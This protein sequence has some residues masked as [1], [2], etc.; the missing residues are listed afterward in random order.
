M[1]WNLDRII[2]YVRFFYFTSHRAEAIYA[3][4]AKM[5]RDPLL[6]AEKSNDPKTLTSHGYTAYSQ[7]D[8]D[9][10]LEEIFRR[11]GLTNRQF[12][13][14]GCGNGLENNSTYLLF[15]G[16]R[17]VWMDG[18]PKEI[19]NVEKHFRSYIQ[20]GQLKVKR[21]FITTDN[22]NDLIREVA[23][24]IQELDLLSIDING[25]DYWIWQALTGLRPRVVVI[26][27][28]A[29]FR[30]P[31]KIVQKYNPTHNWDGSNYFGAS[32]KAL[33][34]LGRQK[35]YILTGCNFAGG[36]AFFIRDDLVG[37]RFSEPFTAEH[38]YRPPQYDAF[39][40]GFSRHPRGAGPYE[41]L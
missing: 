36:N 37:D 15:A 27:Y 11:I 29:T 35:G 3:L 7:A 39:V 1:K 18:D 40:R 34:E 8:E 23:P 28:N 22:I 38:H 4:L 21:A 10:I 14:F 9:G 33:E 16:W 12:L 19:G 25:N 6:A 30:P 20:S 2:Q 41:V 24:D 17:G 32:L 5:Y 13:E 31:H 26:E